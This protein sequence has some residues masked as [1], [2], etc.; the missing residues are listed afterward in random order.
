M[1]PIY[2][3]S[4][5]VSQLPENIGSKEKRWVMPPR[6]HELPHRPHLFKIGRENTGENWVERVC[7][8]IGKALRLPCANYEFAVHGNERGVISETFVPLG[9]RLFLGNLLLSTIVDGYKGTKRFKQIEYKLSRVLNLIRRFPGMNPPMGWE[10]GQDALAAY[11]FFIG[12]LVLDALVGNTD[13]H[14]ENWVS[15]RGRTVIR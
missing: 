11:E 14:H 6:Q 1:F 15:W 8:E 12:Y 7:C 13:R 4:G 5:F 10:E 2:D 9:A 3:I